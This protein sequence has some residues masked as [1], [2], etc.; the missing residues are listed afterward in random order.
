MERSQKAPQK[1]DKSRKLAK[2]FVLMKKN[3]FWAVLLFTQSVFGQDSLWIRQ[4]L[5]YPVLSDTLSNTYLLKANGLKAIVAKKGVNAD[6]LLGFAKIS[7]ENFK[8][9]NDLRDFSLLEGKIY[10]LE[11]KK[12]KGNLKNGIALKED[13]W[14]LLSQRYGIQLAK[15]LELNRSQEFEALQEG[16][17]IFLH[18]KKAKKEAF[19]FVSVANY[20][21]KIEKK[22]EKIAEK[23]LEKIAEKEVL[24]ALLS[25]TNEAIMELIFPNSEAAELIKESKTK[26]STQKNP[27]DFHIVKKGEGLYSIAQKYG[28]SLA[29]IRLWNGF[30][31]KTVIKAGDKV[32]LKDGFRPKKEET[33]IENTKNETP[34]E[35]TKNE[36][37]EVQKQVLDTYISETP[38]TYTTTSS[39][40]VDQIAQRFG[41]SAENIMKWNQLQNKEVPANCRLYLKEPPAAISA[42]FHILEKGETIYGV[43]RK[44]QLSPKDLMDWNNITA[45]SVVKTGDKLFLKSQEN[46]TENTNENTENNSVSDNT[47]N[48]QNQNTQENSSD[49]SLDDLTNQIASEHTEN[50]DKKPISQGGLSADGTYYTVQQELEDLWEIS[51]KVH[52]D[53][54]LIQSLNQ[55]SKT[56]FLQGERILLREGAKLPEET[57][58]KEEQTP[59]P[60]VIEDTPPPTVVEEKA[61]PTPVGNLPAVHIVQGYY[62]NIGNIAEKYGLVAEDLAKLNGLTVEA[63]LFPGTEIKLK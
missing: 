5:S 17:V 63:T 32:Y 57:P 58:Q 16:Q 21:P 36:N 27:P 61:K 2:N 7:K 39:E 44:Y 46:T 20:L 49:L 35:N 42:E 10:Y 62:E 31:E 28:L 1:S 4:A 50:K 6:S 18:E 51:D 11:N 47:D 34:A 14:W 15:L 38:E 53:P 25:P 45:N 24:L 60:S 48:T 13:N 22:V 23:K 30:D 33:K 41:V 8:I 29:T 9:Y 56:T 19:A 59:P 55:T 43:A 54:I 37:K 12:E 52:I 3:I 26:K 40:N